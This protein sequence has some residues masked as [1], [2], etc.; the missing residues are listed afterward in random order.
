MLVSAHTVRLDDCVTQ[1]ISLT[2]FTVQGV[3]EWE[4]HPTLGVALNAFAEKASTWFARFLP[5]P[6][7][8][9]APAEEPKPARK[10]PVVYGDASLAS[11]VRGLRGLSSYE[12]T[13]VEVHPVAAEDLIIAPQQ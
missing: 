12:Y 10:T 1:T 13:P 4:E 11:Y 6:E 7:R 2:N 5:A 9:L 8:P 3:S